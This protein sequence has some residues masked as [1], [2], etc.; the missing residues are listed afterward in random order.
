[1]GGEETFD[2]PLSSKN[3][4][5]RE[6]HSLNNNQTNFYFSSD[7][8]FYQNCDVKTYILNIKKK[9]SFLKKNNNVNK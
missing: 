1:L 9:I 8:D 4:D 6:F 7:Y 2:L 5:N 3:H